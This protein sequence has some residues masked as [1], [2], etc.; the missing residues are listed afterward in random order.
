LAVVLHFS[1]KLHLDFKYLHFCIRNFNK[2]LAIFIK[3]ALAFCILKLGINFQIWEYFIFIINQTSKHSPNILCQDLK[4]RASKTIFTRFGLIDSLNLHHR[5]V[6]K[7]NFA[8][9][10]CYQGSYFLPLLKIFTTP[11]YQALVLKIW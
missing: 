3:I 4:P 11:F 10:C 2:K 5:R 8:L 7:N 9:V 6:V 1:V